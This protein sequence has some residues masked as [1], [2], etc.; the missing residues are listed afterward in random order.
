MLRTGRPTTVTVLGILN[1]IFGS[2]LLLLLLCGGLSLLLLAGLQSSMPRGPAQPPSMF[3]AYEYVQQRQPSYYPFLGLS[4]V[5]GV[6]FA[7]VLLSSGIG[8][9]KV[10]SWARWASILAAFMSL[11]MNL[12]SVV[13]TMVLVNPVTAE[14]QADLGRRMGNP[15]ASGFSDPTMLNV[16]TLITALISAAYPVTLLV[17]L[18]LPHVRR[19]FARAAE[20][21]ELPDEDYDD[22]ED[23]P[24]MLDE[25]VSR[26][27]KGGLRNDQDDY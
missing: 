24:D 20:R 1:I 16:V 9:L 21:R 25:R 13:Y 14:Y 6:V 12:I 17:I 26:R 3:E 5:E 10:R 11:T 22:R 19:A 7:L 23:R 27:P 15:V 8:M 2:G 18:F 4:V